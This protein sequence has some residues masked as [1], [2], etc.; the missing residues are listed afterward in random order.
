VLMVL[1]LCVL[2]EEKGVRAPLR[3]EELLALIAVKG[4][5]LLD[6]RV[7]DLRGDSRASLLF[8]SE[9]AED[10]ELIWTSTSTA[11]NLIPPEK[12][13]FPNESQLL[14]IWCDRVGQNQIGIKL[15]CRRQR[16]GRRTVGM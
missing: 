7:L 14:L 12:V 6:P 9:N 8:G 11:Y 1:N 10:E 4:R 5:L 3:E 13:I 2:R 16:V 15:C